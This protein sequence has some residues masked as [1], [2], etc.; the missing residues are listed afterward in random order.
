MAPWRFQV[1][2]HIAADSHSVL[3]DPARHVLVERWL[4]HG[5]TLRMQQWTQQQ[6]APQRWPALLGDTGAGP[7]TKLA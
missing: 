1:G 4:S 6:K 3:G 2:K 7:D 5:L